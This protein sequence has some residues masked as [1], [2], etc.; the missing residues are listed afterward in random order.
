M[1]VWA[2]KSDHFGSAAT[3]Y[4]EGGN[5]QPGIHLREGELHWHRTLGFTSIGGDS[6][7]PQDTLLTSLQSL[8]QA[9]HSTGVDNLA[10]QCHGMPGGLAILG[11]G[12]LTVG[13]MATYGP[14]WR[15]INQILNNGGNQWPLLMFLSCAA[16]DGEAGNALFSAIS[17][18][19]E[20]TRI[21]GF[22]RILSTDGT[23]DIE[24]DNGRFCLRPDI[25]ATPEQYDAG[26]PIENQ[27]G[28]DQGDIASLPT[29]SPRIYC[30]RE[31]RNGSLYWENTDAIP[32]RQRH[33]YYRPEQSF[34]GRGVVGSPLTR[35]V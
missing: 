19:M 29:A 13:D 4:C 32:H 1:N 26:R 6:N 2:Y 33:G 24:I 35:I 11:N 25:R 34:H 27:R 7:S 12:N 5:S 31:F 30:A 16:A 10:I 17:S 9:Q 23:R 21:V 14:Q 22:T 3:P 20:G 28:A 8:T 15:A 18:W